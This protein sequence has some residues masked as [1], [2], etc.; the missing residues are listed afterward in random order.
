MA[1]SGSTLIQ[2]TTPVVLALGSLAVASGNAHTAVA[3]Q[4]R[5]LIAEFHQVRADPAKRDVLWGHL[6]YLQAQVKLFERRAQKCAYIHMSNY[7]AVIVV[8]TLLFWIGYRNGVPDGVGPFVLSLA[9]LIAWMCYFRIRELRQG[10]VTLGL[11]IEEV[12]N[13]ELGKRPTLG[14]VE[15]Y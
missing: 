7:V 4:A 2:M 14:S 3:N 11:A 13:T 5:Q 8:L 9:V 12:I 10:M 15:G 1:D 6:I